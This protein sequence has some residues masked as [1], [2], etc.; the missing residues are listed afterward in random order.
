VRPGVPLSSSPS[1]LATATPAT[2]SSQA[3]MPM[4]ATGTV[5]PKRAASRP[6]L[7]MASLRL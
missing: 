5:A 7:V 4:P 6:P 1:A 3:F 2:L